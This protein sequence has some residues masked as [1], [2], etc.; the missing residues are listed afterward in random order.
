MYH[1]QS[2][3][4]WTNDTDDAEGPGGHCSW[5]LGQRLLHQGLILWKAFSKTI[6]NDT[7]QH[8]WCWG[9]WRSPRVSVRAKIFAP[10]S[11]YSTHVTS[12]L[13][14]L[15]ASPFHLYIFQESLS[16][17]TMFFKIEW[18]L[19][20]NGQTNP[21]DLYSIHCTVDK[22]FIQTYIEFVKYF[23]RFRERRTITP[24]VS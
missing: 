17:Q 9:S 8:G 18:G 14:W 20:L 1:H 4:M 12:S 7:T 13:L 16:W 24:N 11:N 23:T 6:S 15:A 2:C 22:K 21:F 3:R 10:G 5:V 19:I